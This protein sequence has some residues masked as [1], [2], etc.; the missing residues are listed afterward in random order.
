MNQSLT[1]KTLHTAHD[2]VLGTPLYMSPEQAQL[3]NIDVDTRSD[4]YSLGVLLYELL[5]GSTP[6][7]K[8][9]FKQA[10]WDEMRRIIREETPESPSARVTTMASA[11]K[12]IAA[13]HGGDSGNLAKII[14]GDL[15]VIVM[16]ALE[17]ERGR[18]Y[19]T[20]SAFAEDIGR[21]LNQEAILAKPA[22][23]AY[24]FK[25]FAQRNRGAMLTG[26]LVAASLLLATI[27]STWSAIT[28]SRSRTEAL[29]SRN[30]ALASVAEAI[31]ARSQAEDSAHAAR[32][33]QQAESLRAEEARRAKLE[34]E[35]R[36]AEATA[37]LNFLTN[38]LLAN[39]AP[40]INFLDIQASTPSSN[41]D[42]TT[43]SDFYVSGTTADTQ[44]DL[45]NPTVLELLDRAALQLSEDRIESS[46]PKQPHIQ[47]TVLHTIAQCYS[48]LS[49]FGKALPYAERAAKLAEE[50]YGQQH[51]RAIHA[52][53]VL[54][55]TY[56]GMR[57]RELAQTIAR[58][59]LERS[60]SHFGQSHPVTWMCLATVAYSMYSTDGIYKDQDFIAL[61]GELFTQVAD[62]DASKLPSHPI[63]TDFYPEGWPEFQARILTVESRIRAFGGYSYFDKANE[64]AERAYAII[65]ESGDSTTPASLKVQAN[66][67]YI[68]Y[69]TGDSEGASQIQKATLASLV[70]IYGENHP[71]VSVYSYRLAQ[72]L[73][74]LNDFQGALP[75]LEKEVLIRTESLQQGKKNVPP[76]LLTGVEKRHFD[77]IRE[78]LLNGYLATQRLPDAAAKLSSWLAAGPIADVLL[79]QTALRVV[80]E[81]TKSNQTDDATGLLVGIEQSVRKGISSERLPQAQQFFFRDDVIQ[82]GIY[83]EIAMRH[84]EL[85]D[86]ANAERLAR[87]C[88]AQY[89]RLE[90]SGRFVLPTQTKQAKYCLGCVLLEQGKFDEAEP[91]LLES[92]LSEQELSDGADATVHQAALVALEKLYTATNRPELA[93]QWREKQ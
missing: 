78:Q 24:R 77:R 51:D 74:K 80:N 44:F 14:R 66:L 10:A 19:D 13:T 81:L 47:F 16:K 89:T 62:A 84:L 67:G 52:Q 25:K 22:S 58:Q 75:L 57:Q 59:A 15:D 38:K 3:N 45:R 73:V 46:F 9:R 35:A 41:N 17:K 48:R 56:K 2:M 40:N 5:T 27:A 4:I 29:A 54:S 42:A 21:F 64:L 12:A 37:T 93:K 71:V 23:T 70:K 87:E 33:A 83:G 55:Q 50:L 60:R 79:L 43:E 76:T 53:L 26:S 85:A 11:Q 69:L 18:R 92:L 88:V 91:V 8:Q 63:V 61:H 34:A 31:R 72:S 36:Q 28:A 68:K 20:A 65:K 1:E 86:W 49:E 90:E 82:L 30:E 39:S 32:V 6:V 7:E